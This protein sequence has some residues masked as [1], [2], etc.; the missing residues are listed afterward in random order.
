METLLHPGR[1]KTRLPFIEPWTV[2]GK[3]AQILREGGFERVEEREIEGMAWWDGVGECAYWMTRTLGMMV[4]EGW[5]EGMEEGFKVV[6]ERGL[7]EG[8]GEGL[9][10]TDEGGRVGF[11]TVAFAGV[12]WK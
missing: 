5:G 4:G 9:V 3:L 12:G 1:E 6:L 2:P 8:K 11:R 7:R 10:V